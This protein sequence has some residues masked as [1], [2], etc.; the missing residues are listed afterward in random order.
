MVK[1]TLDDFRNGASLTVD[2]RYKAH[3][4]EP[5]VMYYPNGDGYPGSPPEAEFLGAY[6]WKWEV[7]GEVRRRGDHW[8]WSELDRIARGI[9]ERDWDDTYEEM[10]LRD[11]SEREDE[12]RCLY[13]D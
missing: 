5:M 9:I 6:V 11:A 2:I 10:C 8:A 3:P 1:V 13:D 12:G 7:E 4:G